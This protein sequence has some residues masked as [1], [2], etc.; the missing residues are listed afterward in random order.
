MDSKVDFKN[1][2]DLAFF[3][4]VNASI[5]HELKNILAIISE[6]AGLLQ[7]LTE[8]AAKGQKIE[9]EMLN[10][11]SQDIIEEIQRGFTTIKQMNTFSHSVDVPLKS[12]NLI[13]V[14]NLVI[15]LAGFLSF[16]S[17][18]RFDP[19]QDEAAV[20]LTCP[21]RLQN[22]VYQTLVFAFK[23][24]GADGEI[25][26]TLD[27]EPNGSARI[28][29]SGLGTKGDLSFPSPE[30]KNIAKS[31]GVEIRMADDSQAI[32]ILVTQLDENSGYTQRHN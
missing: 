26:V 10:T 4:K 31:I 9:L 32:D 5:S 21:F 28:V 6:A 8:M 1:N 20:V 19:P 11:C 15:N 27:R 12:V 18:I 17:K 30:T 7:D 24:V 29:F 16:A 23:S 3:G 14:I 2:D 25:Q 22:L 13:E